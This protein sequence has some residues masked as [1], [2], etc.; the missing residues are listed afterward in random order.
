MTPRFSSRACV[1]ESHERQ[2]AIFAE[3][4]DKFIDSFSATFEREFMDVLSRR[5]GTRR[6]Q[7]RGAMISS[8]YVDSNLKACVFLRMQANYVYNE[9]IQQKLHTH[10][11]YVPLQYYSS[12]PRRRGTPLSVTD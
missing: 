6:V 10:S 8:A 1:Q 11:E 2:M 7:V 3:S 9:H 4:P 12:S 5:F